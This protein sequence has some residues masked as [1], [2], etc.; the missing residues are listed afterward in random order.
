MIVF[1]I[2]LMVT[3]GSLMPST[4]AASH[5]AGQMRPVNSGK[6]LV[7]C[8]WRIASLP[9]AAVH[10]IV[11]VGNEVVQRAAGVAE[12]HAAIHAARALRADASLPGTA[13]RSRTSR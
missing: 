11:P 1:S 8:S 2:C 3:G 6:L 13:G 7:A 9:A 5:G 4:Q 12:G 10:Q